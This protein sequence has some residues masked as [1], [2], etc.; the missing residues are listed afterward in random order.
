MIRSKKILFIQ[1]IILIAS[2]PE[3]IQKY[4]KLCIPTHQIKIK[5]LT[6]T[7]DINK[8]VFDQFFPK[9]QQWK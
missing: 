6:I 2:Y 3:K 1:Y 9:F 7:Q 5:I 8:S 4:V